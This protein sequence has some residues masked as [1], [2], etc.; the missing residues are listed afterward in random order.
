MLDNPAKPSTSPDVN[1]G[2]SAQPTAAYFSSERAKAMAAYTLTTF[3]S[4]TDIVGYS[5]F[6]AANGVAAVGIGGVLVTTVVFGVG[7]VGVVTTLAPGNFSV[8]SVSETL[9]VAVGAPGA[10]AG[11]LFGGERGMKAGAYLFSAVSDSG[12]AL[13]STEQVARKPASFPRLLSDLHSIEEDLEGFYNAI[14]G[15]QNTLS[16]QAAPIELSQLSQIAPP[17]A[18]ASDGAGF[19]MGGYAGPDGAGNAGGD[20]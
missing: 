8:E 2:P 10:A 5:A 15:K 11:A 7:I 3:Y 4:A 9:A 12:S 20:A 6:V 1:A 18:K 19:S 16:W 17:G 13:Q 14:V